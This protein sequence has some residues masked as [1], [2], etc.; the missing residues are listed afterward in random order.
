MEF[1]AV[2]NEVPDGADYRPFKSRI[3]ALAYMVLH[4]PHPLVKM[5]TFRVP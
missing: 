3:H 1:E 5:L 2:I 4:S